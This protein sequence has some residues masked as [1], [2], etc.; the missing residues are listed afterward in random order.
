[1][2]E[3]EGPLNFDDEDSQP[4]K[5]LPKYGPPTD[6]EQDF[7]DEDLAPWESPDRDH[8]LA[9]PV[10]REPL[11]L[12]LKHDP[13]NPERRVDVEEELR[14]LDQGENDDE[15]WTQFAR[16][17]SNESRRPRGNRKKGKPPNDQPPFGTPEEE[18]STKRKKKEQKK[19][20]Q[21]PWGNPGDKLNPNEEKIV[22]AM[23]N[24]L[25]ENLIY[26]NTALQDMLDKV[27]HGTDEV[28]HT[29][30]FRWEGIDDDFRLRVAGSP[31][32]DSVTSAF[33]QTHSYKYLDNP[34]FKLSFE[35]ELKQRALPTNE[36]ASAIGHLDS[37]VTELKNDVSEQD[38][39][40][41]TDME[42]LVDLTSNADNR[43]SKPLDPYT[44]GGQYP[45]RDDYDKFSLEGF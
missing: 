14:K 8:E 37:M 34:T 21:R 38:A 18:Y 12:D 24:I 43:T 27:K 40:W 19:K 6:R 17:P 44:G 36:I 20:E 41:N 31:Y 23:R 3:I 33:F 11:P 10:P 28:A 22:L 16:L 7:D 4:K 45:K 15:Y 35:R 26:E 39:G 42:A 5:H 2:P 25:R 30:Q 29:S 32:E 13:D 9:D 1:M